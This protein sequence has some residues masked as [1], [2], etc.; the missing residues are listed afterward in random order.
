MGAG[1]EGP[2][3]ESPMKTFA[4]AVFAV[5]MGLA[6]FGCAAPA[7]TATDDSDFSSASR[8]APRAVEASR[9]AAYALLASTWAIHAVPS[10]DDLM[11]RVYELGGGDP[12]ANGT[13]LKLAI[14]G[15]PG[16]GAIWDLGANIRAVESISVPAAGKVVIKGS[17]DHYDD[18]S[19]R[20]ELVPY[21]ATATYAMDDDGLAAKLIVTTSGVTSTALQEED[22]ASL[23]LIGVYKVSTVEADAIHARLFEVGGGDPVMNGDQLMLSLMSYPDVKTYDLGLDVA[24]VDS[25]TLGP[26]G[27]LRI[28][29]SE[30]WRTPDGDFEQKRF[31]YS[32]RFSVDEDGPAPKI[33]LAAQ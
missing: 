28:Q 2:P 16:L 3:L 25:F 14:D 27:D 4:P 20:F 21:E 1:G 10:P 9:E 22:P 15:G 8:G 32:V 23:F 12:A 13:T 19:G 26:A 24:A 6:S 31:S 17:Q 33:T 5:L 11:I 30:D 29:G 7:D 18:A